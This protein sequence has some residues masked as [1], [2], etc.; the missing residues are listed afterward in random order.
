MVQEL[1]T[2]TRDVLKKASQGE[3]S[4][5]DLAVTLKQI[6]SMI[7]LLH[8]E[9]AVTA[10]ARLERRRD[11]AAQIIVHP[12]ES[13]EPDPIGIVV[14]DGS[15]GPYVFT[16]TAS[17]E[18]YARVHDYCDEG[19]LFYTLERSWTKGLHRFLMRGYG[20]M[21]I[22]PE[23]G[24]EI[25]MNRQTIA[26]L[27]AQYTLQPFAELGR[28][29]VAL[30]AGE[31]HLQKSE[32]SL[33]AVVF[34]H[35]QA[36]DFFKKKM[37]K[38]GHTQARVEKMAMK[39]FLHWLVESGVDEL[40]VNPML[41]DI[42]IY[43]GD[44]I[45]KMHRLRDADGHAGAKAVET[46]PAEAPIAEEQPEEKEAPVPVASDRLPLVPRPSRTKE[47]SR[48][49][50]MEWQRKFNL[51]LEEPWQL[52][53]TLAFD[54][55]LYV[56]QAVAAPSGL[57][58]PLTL[59]D[60][61]PEASIAGARMTPVY[62]NEDAARR[63]VRDEL[64]R[65]YSALSGIEALRWIW[66][67]PVPAESI[68]IDWPDAT[69]W[70]K[71]PVEFGVPA[72]FPA[73]YPIP[74]LK[75]VPAASLD[76]LGTLSGARALKPEVLHSLTRN[77]KAFL[78]VAI[79]KDSPLPTVTYESKSYLPLFSS[80]DAF[81]AYQPEAGAPPL[82]PM[83]SVRV[84]AGLP[85]YRTWLK[86]TTEIDGVLLDPGCAKPLALDHFDLLFLYLRATKPDGVFKS[87]VLIEAIE[88]LLQK[89]TID[90]RFAGRLAA[91]WPSYFTW[92]QETPDGD[93]QPLSF[94]DDGSLVVFSET[95]LA[96]AYAEAYVRNGRLRPDRTRLVPRLGRWN[97]NVFRSARE[98][99]VGL[100]ID[101]APAVG[102]TG[103]LRLDPGGI[104]AA[105][106]QLDE[107]LAPRVPALRGS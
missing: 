72:L 6:P 84:Q 17:A 50:F 99:R 34:D 46:V 71:I 61:D 3:A 37:H 69:G 55:D 97:D 89:G 40:V 42:R 101:P 93:E 4:A 8:P 51:R 74:N 102:A 70:L 96:K 23:S 30:A 59:P 86:A 31:I 5:C 13:R 10:E 27:F 22:D 63:A 9:N 81:L 28:I 82:T 29:H 77:W 91:R 58:W 54:M 24:A 87:G 48:R 88:S 45:A 2:V 76:Q 33:Q 15:F 12:G 66:S 107:I 103:G 47:A 67:A 98:K 38:Q 95:D 18:A 16:E 49:F 44:D 26:E 75:Q 105:L 20:G 1:G 32:N 94:Q 68:A 25:L 14:D 39:S 43:F 78:G 53:E 7:L 106:E 104:D 35:D 56:P 64:F 79:D 11:A 57:S 100:W 36:A 41:P 21:V 85:P 90:Q 19:G 65:D 62:S 83:P 92:M 80:Q 73:Y 60:P 52:A